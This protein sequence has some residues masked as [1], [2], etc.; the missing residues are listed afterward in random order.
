M[1]PRNLTAD[2]WKTLKMDGPYRK[3]CANLP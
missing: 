2:E 1:M 3:T